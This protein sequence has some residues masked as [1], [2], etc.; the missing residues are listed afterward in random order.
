MIVR[1]R[2]APSP[3]GMLHIGN[4][5]TAI[6]NWLYAKK[7][8]GEFIL[9]IDDTDLAR[10]KEEFAQAIMEDLKW[11]GLNWDGT[12][13]Q[14]EKIARYEEVKKQLIASGRLYPC[15]ETPEELE[16]KRGLQ[17]KSGH[18]P[19]Y[20][21]AALKLTEEQKQKYN[22]QGRAPHYRFLV[23]HNKIMWHDMVKGDIQYDGAN[24]SDPIIIR[25][26]GS[27]T[28]MLCSTIDD[29]D[30]AITHIIRGED[31]ISNTA[32]QMQIFEALE[33]TAPIVGHLSLV[34]SKE[35]KISK[36]VGGFE[37]ASLR[38]QAKLEPMA[39]N[40]FLSLIGT[41]EQVVPCKNMEML[42]AKFSIS[43]FSKSSTTYMPEE[44]ER[45][46]HK[47]IINLEYSEVKEELD[48]LGLTALQEQFWY[49]V[50]PNLHTIADIQLWW[51]VC[52]E[53]VVNIRDEDREYLRSAADL[54]PI[55]EINDSTWNNWTKIISA[56]TGKRGKELFLPLRLAIT[57]LTEGPELST[58]LPLIGREEI[59]HRL[60]YN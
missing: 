33:A 39:I 4:A 6:I 43:H 31:H 52:H 28:Y 30:S 23:N 26:D 56:E 51:R 9:R 58:L 55:G 37:I 25:E 18:P 13:R 8:G 40:S 60:G 50:R 27:M 41:S 47:L 5:R 32:I 10:S 35:D 38:T 2:F 20:D 46:N 44:L 59:L 16:M 54:L 29:V 53:H 11:L 48:V 34:K 57:G 24:L 21:R 17:L 14:S 22:E 15:Y 1:T 42:L 3:T 45:L 49:A 36:R 19:I 7:Y 12:F